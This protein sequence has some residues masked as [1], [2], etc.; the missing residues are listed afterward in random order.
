MMDLFSLPSD[1]HIYQIFNLID[2]ESVVRS[3]RVCKEWG[4]LIKYILPDLDIDLSNNKKIMDDDLI[5]F[6][7]CKNINLKNTCIT[8]DCFSKMWG[9]KNLNL[10]NCFQFYDSSFKYLSD[11]EEI[12]LRGTYN[13]DNYRVNNNI[14]RLKKLK[15]SSFLSGNKFNMYLQDLIELEIDEFII[16]DNLFEKCPNLKKIIFNRCDFFDLMYWPKDMKLYNLTQTI[17]KDCINFSSEFFKSLSDTCDISII[18]VPNDLSLRI[19][20]VNKD[21][22]LFYN[23]NF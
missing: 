4:S 12:N 19:E 7:G 2:T 5:F 16:N 3:R 15:I 6:N 9:V 22:I 17:L 13:S 18:G 10:E 14:F 8:G 1:I 20:H 23:I 21:T 11:L